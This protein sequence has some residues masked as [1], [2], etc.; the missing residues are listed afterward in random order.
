MA[1]DFR[2]AITVVDIHQQVVV[3]QYGVLIRRTK[4]TMSVQVMNPISGKP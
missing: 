4:S 2:I 3:G 1:G